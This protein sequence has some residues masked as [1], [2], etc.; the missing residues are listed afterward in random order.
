MRTTDAAPAHGHQHVG[1]EHCARLTLAT[2]T[3]DLR[4]EN[5]AGTATAV[6]GESP[7]PS[8]AATAGTDDRERHELAPLYA[9]ATDGEVAVLDDLRRRAAAPHAHRPT[10]L[11]PRRAVPTVRS[12]QDATCELFG[13]TREQL[14]SRSRT[15]NVTWPRHVAMYLARELTHNSL[16]MLGRE[17]GRRDHTT[18]L[19]G[20]RRTAARIQRDPPAHA[21][22]AHLT[23]AI[24]FGRPA[25]ALPHGDRSASQ[26]PLKDRREV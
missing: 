3:P 23:A 19:H 1:P 17:F 12:I 4:G 15:A 20:C 7:A 18:V 21:A 14:L 11:G 25:P 26:H 22:I 5:D 10:G 24:A 9:V 8:E 2:S 13:V 16:T 6:R